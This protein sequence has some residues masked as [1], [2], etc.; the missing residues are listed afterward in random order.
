MFRRTAYVIAIVIAEQ[1]IGR[2][3]AAAL[4]RFAAE[5][6]V[7]RAAREADAEDR[8]RHRH[9]PGNGRD[10]QLAEVPAEQPVLLPDRRRGAA[11]DPAGRRTDEA[12]AAVPAAA[13]RAEGAIEGP[14]LVPGPEAVQLTGI[15]AV[16][17]ARGSS[18]RRSKP[19]RSVKRTAYLPFRPEVLGGASVSDPR[20]RWSGVGSR[21]VGRWQAARDAVPRKGQGGGAVARRPGPRPADRRAAVRQEPARD[22]ADPR[23]DADRRPGDD[24]SDAIG[25]DG[26]VRV[27]D[28]GDRRLHLQGAQRAGRRLLRARRRRQEQRLSALPRGADADEG[29]RPGPVR[30]RAR[31]QVLRLGRH[32]RV[33][34]QRQ[35]LAGS[36]RAVRHLRQAVQGADDVDQA[37]RAGARRS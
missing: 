4:H 37:E 28:R 30:L 3:R 17:A 27:R 20:A 15:E 32:P 7:R 8:R 33:P 16:E 35:V 18:M 14:V 24:G 22:R 2:V 12:V 34:D 13:R 10:R 25:A 36:A 29:R 9:H 1:C 26:H 5:G 6:G 31:L 19:R 11:R 23:V 21:S